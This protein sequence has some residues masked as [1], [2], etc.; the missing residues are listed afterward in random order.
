MI[1]PADIAQMEA[2]YREQLPLKATGREK[3]FMPPVRLHIPYTD[4]MWLLSELEPDGM[5]FGLCQISMAE[6][7][8]VW[9]PEL[10]DIAVQGLRVIQ[11][12]E[13]VPKMTLGQYAD[14]SRANHWMIVL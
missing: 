11:D 1:R 7:G 8:S 4:M 10:A 13:F 9:L 3:D 5:A 12:L 14:R 6:L 2:N